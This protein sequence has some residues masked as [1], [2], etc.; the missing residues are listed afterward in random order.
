ME[1]AWKQTNWILIQTLKNLS[2]VFITIYI[3]M[4][5][6]LMVFTFVFISS[7]KMSKKIISGILLCRFHLGKMNGNFAAKFIW[8]CAFSFACSLAGKIFLFKI[9]I[10][11]LS[12]LWWKKSPQLLDQSKH[13]YTSIFALSTNTFRS[14]QIKDHCY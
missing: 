11:N 4:V 3:F 7:N 10:I 8:A 13:K 2:S 1:K 6:W 5:I 9:V 14:D 12:N